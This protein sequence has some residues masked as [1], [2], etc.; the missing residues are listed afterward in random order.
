[1][2]LGFQLCCSCDRIELETRGGV[3]V[4]ALKLIGFSLCAVVALTAC[5]ESSSGSGEGELVIYTTRSE[6]LNEA[7]IPKFEEE[8]GIKVQTISAGTGEVVTRVESER[9]N[10]QGIYYGQLMSPCF[11]TKR[12]Y[13]RSMYLLKMSL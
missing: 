10:P 7:V 5:G 12:I 9:N 13:L 8:T 6:N 11:M 1:M 2:I 4:K 3:I